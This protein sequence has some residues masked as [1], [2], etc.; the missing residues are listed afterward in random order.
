MALMRDVAGKTSM[1]SARPP[2]TAT[3]FAEA[4]ARR[5]EV[6]GCAAAAS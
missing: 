4:V 2:V 1:L 3:G 5:K 6:R